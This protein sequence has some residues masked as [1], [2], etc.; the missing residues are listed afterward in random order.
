[1][2][3]KNGA[4]KGEE[5]K[6]KDGEYETDGG[7]ESKSPFDIFNFAQTQRRHGKWEHIFRISPWTYGQTHIVYRSL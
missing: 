7:K 1:M 2:E 6:K 3:E 5:R 4:G